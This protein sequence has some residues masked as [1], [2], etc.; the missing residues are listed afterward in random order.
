VEED[1]MDDTDKVRAS[2]EA[3]M[4]AVNNISWGDER[5]RRYAMAA[6]LSSRNQRVLA[7]AYGRGSASDQEVADFTLYYA[8]LLQAVAGMVRA[9]AG[10][11]A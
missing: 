4:D 2:I 3:L 11:E 9:K 8:D 10:G 5:A 1:A 7:S 6:Q